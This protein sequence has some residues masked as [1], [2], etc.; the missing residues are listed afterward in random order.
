[1]EKG[2]LA[3]KFSL[4][5]W[6]GGWNRPSAEEKKVLTPGLQRLFRRYGKPWGTCW[7]EL[8]DEQGRTTKYHHI[9]WRPAYYAAL[10]ATNILTPMLF[11]PVLPF[12]G[13]VCAQLLAGTGGPGTLHKKEAKPSCYHDRL[14]VTLSRAQYDALKKDLDARAGKKTYFNL[15]A[16]NCSNFAVDAARKA[17]V[18]SLRN[19]WGFNCPDLLAR[20]IERLA[21]ANG[22]NPAAAAAAAAA[23]AP[24]RA[25]SLR[26]RLRALSTATAPSI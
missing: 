18:T 3:C 14:D 5:V 2:D 1:M 9:S 15:L 4:V 16:H 21:A 7:V 19:Y 6:R 8:E 23:T 20:Q 10:L 17:G 11:A 26:Q 24:V 13:L 12:L 25:V 22:N